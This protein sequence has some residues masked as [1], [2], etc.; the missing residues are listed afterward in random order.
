[1][2]KPKPN[3]KNWLKKLVKRERKGN[4]KRSA[5]DRKIECDMENKWLRQ[6]GLQKNKPWNV[7]Y[8]LIEFKKRKMKS[9]KPNYLS[10]WGGREIRSW[11]SSNKKGLLHKK[12]SKIRSNSTCLNNFNYNVNKWRWVCWLIQIK[13]KCFF[14]LRRFTL[15]ILSK[16]MDNKSSGK[17][18]KRIRHFR[19]EWLNVLEEFKYWKCLAIKKKTIS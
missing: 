14:K 3:L 9:T 1:M 19:L 4:K 16:I 13:P 2:N 11:G 15:V 17:S 5:R 6:S 8:S 18:I 7:N 12:R 10:K